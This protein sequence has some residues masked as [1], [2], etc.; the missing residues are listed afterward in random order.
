[1]IAPNKRNNYQYIHN[2]PIQVVTL[3]SADDCV[4][5]SIHM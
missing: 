4:I 1:M 5:L 3:T 2:F